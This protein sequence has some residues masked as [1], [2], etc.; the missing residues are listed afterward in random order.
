MKKEEVIRAISMIMRGDQ[1]V[2]LDYPVNPTPRYG[3]GKPSHPLLH[4]IIDSGRAEYRETLESFLNFEDYFCQISL[5]KLET[6][7]EPFWRNGYIE[8][9]D[10]VAL[11]SL[12]CLHNPQRYIE[13]GSGYSTMFAR[14][15]IRDH[16]L[17]TK[18]IS[19]DPLPRAD[20]D[21]IC[22]SIIRRPLED[23]DLRI[24]EELECGD[25]IYID[26]THRCFANSD[27]T[28]IFMDILPRLRGI[29]LMEFHD[30]LLPCDYPPIWKDRY[31]SEQYL[32]AVYLMASDRYKIIL[33]NA[34]VNT[35]PE[36]SHVLDPL[37]DNEEMKGVNRDG[38]SF[39][40]QIS[41]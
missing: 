4:K 26:G 28:V 11:Y 23:I 6:S 34:F 3:Y 8:G 18:L 31:Y 24:F 38:N 2:F 5:N 25:I 12:L 32:L 16:H 29:A 20:I 19:L 13:I 37:W 15:A 1:P 14:R 9:G 21:C 10:A 30:I 22:D 17:K 36:L 35:D 40:V 41:Q 7:T 27:V 39:W 33:P